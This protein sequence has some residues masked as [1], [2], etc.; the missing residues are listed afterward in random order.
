MQGLR[1]MNIYYRLGNEP[2]EVLQEGETT[3]ADYM[4]ADPHSRHVI[5]KTADALLFMSANGLVH[6]DIKHQHS[7]Y[8]WNG[9]NFVLVLVDW[10]FGRD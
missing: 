10:G 1:L 6:G 4:R 2:Q 3:W 8:R 7:M 9:T 5:I